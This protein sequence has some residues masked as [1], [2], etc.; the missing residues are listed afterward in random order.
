MTTEATT[1]QTP[2][3]KQFAD[4]RLWG[5]PY[6]PHLEIPSNNLARQYGIAAL[7]WLDAL[8]AMDRPSDQIT[9][10]Y[11]VGHEEVAMALAEERAAAEKFLREYARL[12]CRYA[13]RFIDRT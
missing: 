3:R 11:A 7:T 2:S 4:H 5:E 6:P 1:P 8:L 13:Q 9:F 12:A 10:G